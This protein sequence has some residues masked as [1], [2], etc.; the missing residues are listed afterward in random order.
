MKK[1]VLAIISKKVTDSDLK[2]W[3]AQPNVTIANILVWS[4]TFLSQKEAEISAFKVL[5]YAGVKKG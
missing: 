5:P 4:K 2:L 3:S 1:G